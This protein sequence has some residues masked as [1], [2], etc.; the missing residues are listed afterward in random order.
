MLVELCIVTI[1][2][3]Y[4]QNQRSK[5]QR[6]NQLLSKRI[7]I[8]VRWVVQPELHIWVYMCEVLGEWRTL[9]TLWKKRDWNEVEPNV[10]VK[11]RHL[12]CWNTVRVFFCKRQ[13][14]QRSWD[15]KTCSSSWIYENGVSY[16]E[17]WIMYEYAK[18]YHSG[19][20]LCLQIS[21]SFCSWDKWLTLLLLWIGI[22]LGKYLLSSWA[23]SSCSETKWYESFYAS[24]IDCEDSCQS[25]SMWYQS[26]ESLQD[27]ADPYVEEPIRFSRLNFVIWEFNSDFF[28]RQFCD[29]HTCKKKLKIFPRGCGV[30]VLTLF[31]LLLTL[32]QTFLILWCRDRIQYTSYIPNLFFP[33][34][35]L[36]EGVWLTIVYDH[37]RM[38][39]IFTFV[40][41][42]AD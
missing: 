26:S 25:L 21:G 39:S 5:L 23:E 32:C 18:F 38:L 34:Y 16:Y 1:L 11:K 42:D 36:L 9:L 17:I 2:T 6:A 22:D 20:C 7:G 14:L 15:A 33:E 10:R 35:S 13:V 24:A 30:F 31:W 3:V 8:L 41:T 4:H 29:A 28:K 37:V 27:D 40:I 19:G 12:A